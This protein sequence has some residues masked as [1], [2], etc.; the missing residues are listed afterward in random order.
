MAGGKLVRSNGGAGGGG[1]SFCTKINHRLRSFS[2]KASSSLKFQCTSRSSEDLNADPTGTRIPP[3]RQNYGTL[4]S[5]GTDKA[6]N[7]FLFETV[8]RKIE[9]YEQIH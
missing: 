9:K 4:M 6:Q 2:S 1:D 8:Q 5:Y 7:K 3:Q